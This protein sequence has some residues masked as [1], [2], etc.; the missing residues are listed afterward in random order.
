M[1]RLLLSGAVALTAYAQNPLTDAV[2]A[3][4]INIRQSLIESADVM[5][6]DAYSFRLTSGQR[7]FAEWVAHVAMGNYGYCAVIKGEKAPDTAQLHDASDRAVLSEA[8]KKSFAYC[9]AALAGMTDAKALVAASVGGQQV[10]PVT[11]MVNLVASGNEHYGN[12]V[13]YMRAKGIT[14]PS[15]ARAKK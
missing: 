11:G 1:F 8:L 14:P 7:T 6:A 2:M 3:R 10:Y 9:D 4:Y 13:G 15:T 12:V 5:P